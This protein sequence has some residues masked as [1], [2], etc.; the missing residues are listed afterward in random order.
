MRRLHNQVVLTSSFESRGQIIALTQLLRQLFLPVYG[1]T[2]LLSAGQG[3]VM[4]ILPLAAQDLGASIALAGIIAALRGLGNYIFDIPAGIVVGRIGE[5]WSILC[6]GVSL[7]IACIFAIY[8][9]TV[10]NSS[11]TTALICFSTVIFL[12]GAASSLW[13]VARLVYI[14]GSCSEELRG[15]GISLVGGFTRAGRFAGPVLAAFLYSFS[16]L[17]M[18]FVLFS[19][20]TI[21]ALV[22]IVLS[23]QVLIYR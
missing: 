3:A 14:A 9:I 5:R 19:I 15:R 17:E 4:P 2:F 18:A 6:S 10:I 16:G 22:L 20:F 12:M 21:V 7:I 11:T 1:P 23:F 13:Q 8:A